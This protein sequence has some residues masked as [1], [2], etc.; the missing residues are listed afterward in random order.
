MRITSLLHWWKY[1]SVYVLCRLDKDEELLSDEYYVRAD[2]IISRLIGLL[3]Y[4]SSC[5]LEEQIKISGIV[6]PHCSAVHTYGMNVALDIAFLD[7]DQQVMFVAHHVPPGVR[8]SCVSASS[9]I[10]RVVRQQE[11]VW[12]VRPGMTVRFAH[13]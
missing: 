8:I 5:A 10:E 12:Q 11:S 2:G 4:T 6:L 13:V 7:D 9:I 3:G 1:R